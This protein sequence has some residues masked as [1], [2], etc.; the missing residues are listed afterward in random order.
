MN[1]AELD[2]YSRQLL[3][4]NFDI[5]GQLK[6][7]KARV[8][9]VGLGGLGNIAATYLATSGVGHL[10]LADGDQLENSNLPRQVLY[11]ENQTGLDKV[12]AAA[13]QIALKNSAVNIETITQKLSGDALLNAVEEADVVLDCTD[14]FTARQAI[15]RACLLLKKPLVSAAAIRWEGQLVSFLFHQQDSPCYEC[16][17]PSLSE[18]PLSC[19]ESG[20]VAPVVGMLGVF[21]ALEGL[22]LASGCGN[23]QHGVLRLFDGFEGRW[24]EMRLTSDAECLACS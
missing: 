10:T 12:A 9:V 13:A 19:N 5:Q 22:K 1:E 2:R 16:L 8:L 7:A 17:Y 14:N 6:L 15:N 21:Q 18:Q 3:L 11:N 20:V 4:P 23:V 24:R